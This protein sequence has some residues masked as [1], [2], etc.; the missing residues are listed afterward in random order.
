MDRAVYQTIA[1]TPTPRLDAHLTR[2]SNA[3]NHSRLWLGCA[4]VIAAVGGRQGRRVAILG[5]ASIGLASAVSNLI[6]KPLFARGRPDRDSTEDLAGRRV[7]MPTS[8]SL[9]S[10]HSASAFAFA[11]AVGHELPGLSLPL[12]AAAAAVAYSRVHTGVHYPVDA[13]VG[14]AI[15]ASLAQVMCHLVDKRAPW[16]TARSCSTGKV[17]RR[18]ARP[19]SPRPSR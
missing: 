14:S 1:A 10:G 6:A 8:S 15:G 7:R 17:T 11:T 18:P 2:L 3:A 12:T 19:A 13:M 16:A 9:P 5:V 4:A